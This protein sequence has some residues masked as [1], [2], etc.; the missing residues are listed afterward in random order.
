MNLLYVN[1]HTCCY[2]Y[3]TQDPTIEYRVLKKGETFS[4]KSLDNKILM[5]RH[6][7]LEYSF[8]TQL[9][10]IL[11][12][13][14]M[15][16]IPINFDLYLNVLEDSTIF[17]FRIKRVPDLCEQYG[18][19]KLLEVKDKA[20]CSKQVLTINESIDEYLNLLQKNLSAGFKCANFLKLKL[21]ELFFLFRA[22]YKKECLYG[23]FCCLL[24]K[25]VSFSNYILQ[26]YHKA[27]T[28]KDLAE[29]TN[30]SIS[31]FEK[32][33]KKV[34]N[35]SA[36]QWM[37][38]QKAK[39]IFQEINNKNLTFKEISYKHGFT[40]PAHFNDFCKNHFGMT[41]GQM[42]KQKYK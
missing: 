30:Y 33:F 11:S 6:G 39:I 18:L 16:V 36:S 37:K 28:V 31:G 1:E 9:N 35:T 27:R 2:N 5:V 17:I 8:G 41:P 24:T 21:R 13:E 3:M 20:D 14:Q 7:C 10:C 22:Y 12:S 29:M 23:F 26:N 25:N 40:S 15:V 42:R 38:N 4:L 32:H 34:F 19:E